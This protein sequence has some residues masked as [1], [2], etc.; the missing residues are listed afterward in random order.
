MLDMYG[1]LRAISASSTPSA[2]TIVKPV[3]DSGPVA[4]PL[5]QLSRSLDNH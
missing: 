4:N 5:F 1:L 2:L 3:M